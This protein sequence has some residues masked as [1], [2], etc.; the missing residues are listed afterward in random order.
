MSEVKKGAVI[1]YV[2][3]VVGGNTLL[4]REAN[5]EG[6]GCPSLPSFPENFPIPPNYYLFLTR[7][8][9]KILASGRLGGGKQYKIHLAITMTYYGHYTCKLSF[10]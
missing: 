3:S 10:F 2:D 8:M 5:W 9:P 6:G 4:Y 1:K 7:L